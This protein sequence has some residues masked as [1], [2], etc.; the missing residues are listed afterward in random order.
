MTKIRTI[1]F[2]IVAAC[3]CFACYCSAESEPSLS[4]TGAVRQPLH[5]TLHDLARYQPV[6]V[7]L[8]EVGSDGSF[9]GV[10]TYQGVPLRYLLELASP[11]KGDTGFPS[12]IDLALRVRSKK[13]AE[14]ALSWGEI[15]YK[16]PPEFI[17]ATAAVPVKSYK[18]CTACHANNEHKPR[19]EQ[20]ER[21]P[22]FPK[23]VV[24][25]DMYADRCLEDISSIEIMDLRPRTG[26]KELPGLY[27][28]SI[29][30]AG[31]GNRPVTVK[32]LS[33]FP[34]VTIPFRQ[35]DCGG[36]HGI[37]YYGGASLK[38]IV[39]ASGA[40]FDIASVL[41]VW[42]PD[43]YRASVSYGDL[44]LSGRGDRIM[45][46]DRL[47]DAPLE[48]GGKYYLVFPDD[49]AF[50]RRVD[51]VSKIEPVS[52]RDAAKLHVV[53]VGCGDTS[54]LTLQAISA[55]AKADAFVCTEDIKKRFG[56]Y[57]GDKP[58]LFDMYDY[59]QH[60]I[61]KQN[62]SLVEDALQKLVKEKQSHAAGII[63]GMLTTNKSVA[64]L[65][66]GDPAIFTGSA[67]VR[68]CFD[69]KDLV[70][71][72]GISSFNAANALLNK[73]FDGN[74]TLVLTTPWDMKS[75][76]AL[77]KAAGARNEA[78]VIFMGLTTPEMV[79]PLLRAA[80][81]AHTPAHIVCQAGYAAGARVVTATIASLEAAIAQE[82]EKLLGLIYVAPPLQGGCCQ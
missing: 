79:V 56:K 14:V 74:R 18:D 1:V 68:D 21:T 41:L 34:A 55:M 16:N 67:W 38:K 49:L 12:P 61:K 46:A 29:E 75:N 63:K 78:M 27:S 6:E 15:F 39:E 76:P 77:V 28:S 32:R 22:A 81:P 71:V 72:P 35:G 10:F 50:E 13:G 73:K 25:N 45:I 8:H 5:L 4:I 33:S 3:L 43:G 36:Y 30:M 53:G 66:Y 52:L 70:V 40:K 64:L 11:A 24:G 59:T 48:K 58:V 57:M 9:H 60:T 2:Q 69:E 17:V 44:F 51:A 31:P 65:D 37:Q 19:L 82:H 54:L 26:A 23:L 47:N 62:P 7:Q 20:Y 42:A 80:Y